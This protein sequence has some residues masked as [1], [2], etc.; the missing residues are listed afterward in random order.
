LAEQYVISNYQK[1]LVRLKNNILIKINANFYR[2]N[3]VLNLMG[4]SSLVRKE[5]GWEPKISFDKL[6]EE[7]VL[8]D[9]EDGK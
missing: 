7:M 1:D 9:I 6:V 8:F 5:L 2:P 3:E 4:N